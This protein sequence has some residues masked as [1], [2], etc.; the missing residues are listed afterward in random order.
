MSPFVSLTYKASGVDRKWGWIHQ[1]SGQGEGEKT[2]MEMKWEDS[3]WHAINGRDL[4][5]TT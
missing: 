3:L 1:Q 4:A 2:H 5:E